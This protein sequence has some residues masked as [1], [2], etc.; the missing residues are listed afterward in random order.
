[1]KKYKYLYD[2][3]E[4]REAKSLTYL[5]EIA[6]LFK[7]FKA[8][9]GDEVLSILENISLFSNKEE[10]VVTFKAEPA[11]EPMMR[12]SG[13]LAE[14]SVTMA[15]GKKPLDTDP[16]VTLSYK[17]EVWL[18]NDFYQKASELG[19]FNSPILFTKPGV[20]FEIRN[21]KRITENG[22]FITKIRKISNLSVT[23]ISTE[24]VDGHGLCGFNLVVRMDELTPS[25]QS[26]MLDFVH[27][28]KERGKALVTQPHK[29]DRGFDAFA[30]ITVSEGKGDI[31]YDIELCLE[32]CP[33]S[34][35]DE[36][37]E[38]FSATE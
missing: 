21:E 19:M 38:V 33:A 5:S 29:E 25:E 28:T 6:D 18:D 37:D 20:S 22:A 14:V 8:G 7:G 15:L 30:N 32:N 2:Q 10:C 27:G 26:R 13:H 11:E 16:E 1:M 36:R 3:K 34:L 24:N 35:L 31:A 9:N 4:P 12:D 23:F 17:G